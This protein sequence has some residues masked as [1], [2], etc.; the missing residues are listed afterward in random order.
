[1]T[2][3]G[4]TCLFILELRWEAKK[5][6]DFYFSKDLCRSNIKGVWDRWD[7]FSFYTYK[8][9]IKFSKFD[10]TEK[11]NPIPFT[12]FVERLWFLTCIKPDILYGVG[13]SSQFI[14]WQTRTHIKESKW[15]LRYIKGHWTM[16]SFILLQMISDYLDLIGIDWREDVDD[17]KTISGFAFSWALLYLLGVQ[18]N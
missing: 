17:R 10:N 1:M 4:I 6:I 11:V 15:I 13:I 12:R 5:R 18:R 3:L 7:K 16:A 8:C 14:K 9:G 2:N